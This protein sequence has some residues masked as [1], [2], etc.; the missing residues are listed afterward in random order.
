MLHQNYPNPFNPN[1]LIDYN[2]PQDGIVRISV[3]DIK[4]REVSILLEDEQT[5][6]LKSISWRGIDDHGNKLPSGVYICL[7]TA[8]GFISTIKMI[9]LQ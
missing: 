5:A 8:N 3:L 2:L 1:T 7:M 9:L 6:G 4:G